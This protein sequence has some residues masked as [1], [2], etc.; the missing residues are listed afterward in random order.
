[1]VGGHAPATE[2][3]PSG[4]K[5]CFC[6]S[7]K[8][9]VAL[10][11]TAMPFASTHCEQAERW[12]RILRVN[13]AVGNAMQALGLPEEPFAPCGPAE[14]DDPCHPGAVE[15]VIA[16]AAEELRA[17]GGDAISTEDLFVGVRSVYGPAFERALGARGTTSGEVLEL[18]SRRG[19]NA[20]AM[21]QF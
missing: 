11:A 9:A 4:D 18:V 1:M 6:G 16:A 3:T 13:G 5:Q 10:A 8:I 14:D 20:A 21:R 19:A 7:A 12:L 2:L 17:R 15:A